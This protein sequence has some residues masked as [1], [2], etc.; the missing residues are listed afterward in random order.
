M[1][2]QKTGEL[3]ANRRHELGYTQK[4]L[5]ERLGIS[6][7]TVSKWERGLGFPDISLVEDLADALG[8]TAIELLRGE[9]AVSTPEEVCSVQETIHTFSPVI[10]LQRKKTRIKLIAVFLALGIVCAS[11][12]AYVLWSTKDLVGAETGVI[13]ITVAEATAICPYIIINEQDMQLIDALLQD[14]SVQDR[15]KSTALHTFDDSFVAEYIPL[16]DAY[17][18]KLTQ[19]TI[20]AFRDSVWIFYSTELTYVTLGKDSSGQINKSVLQLNS[21]MQFKE[22]SRFDVVAP[23]DA[24]YAVYNINNKHFER[25]TYETGLQVLF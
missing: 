9:Q 2:Q 25:K 21:P 6:D 17:D 16:I 23:P 12:A 11:F 7:R 24:R 19:V 5:A 15:M 14:K 3:I 22:G 20:Q 10:Q 18:M 4:Q 1:D 13:S 8:L